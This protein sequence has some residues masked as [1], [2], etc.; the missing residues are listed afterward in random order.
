MRF[1]V[2]LLYAYEICELPRW[3]SSHFYGYRY[4]KLHVCK[5]PHFHGIP[6]IGDF[7]L[8]HRKLLNLPLFV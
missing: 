3:A 7:N 1:N 8:H 6:N 4:M 5:Y 2:L